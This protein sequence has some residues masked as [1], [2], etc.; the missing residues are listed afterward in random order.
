[1]KTAQV[2]GFGGIDQLQ[3]V[4][5]PEPEPG[6]GELLIRVKACGLNGSDLLQREGLY[7]GGPKPP[8]FPGLEGA[9]VVELHGPEVDGP[10]IGSAVAFLTSG[11]AQ[12]G[13]VVVKPE[14]CIQLPR[15]LSFT[16]GAAF[17]LQYLTAY[18]ALTTVAHA[19]PGETVLIHAAGG[20]LGT[21]AVQ[22]ARMLG[23]R[24]AAT[25]STPE[26]RTRILELG[27]DAVAGYEDFETASRQFASSRGPDIILDSV[28]GDVFGRSL[29]LLP[30]LG[31]LL[32]LG[33]SSRQT[34]T[35]ETANLLFRS[36]AV[37]G[38]H[39]SA[40]LE[41]PALVTASLEQMINWIS[42][43]KIKPQVGH[44]LPLSAVREAHEL[45]SSRKSYG[46]IVLLPD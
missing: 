26:K 29:A 43:G 11:G 15:I 35:I 45:L 34:Q 38:F 33:L 46:K 17:P 41:R 6:K 37:L 2:T 25:A 23:L 24:I 12:A 1:M 40:V 14:A 32:V 19:T 13:F 20:G 18:H 28:G 22:L 30:P 10:P 9:G 44:T 4:E 42:Q 39:L 36:K 31:R 3:I 16:E 5:V 7:P 21:A 8:Y 27:A